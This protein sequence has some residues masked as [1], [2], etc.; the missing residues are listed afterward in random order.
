MEEELTAYNTYYPETLAYF[1]YYQTR[2][3]KNMTFGLESPDGFTYARENK[4]RISVASYKHF[5]CARRRK[6]GCTAYLHTD[7]DERRFKLYE[8]GHNCK[9]GKSDDEGLK[10]Y[11]KQWMQRKKSQFNTVT[12]VVHDLDHMLSR[13]EM[14]GR[15]R[16]NENIRRVQKMKE[17]LSD[18]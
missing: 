8:S 11:Y 7:N 18:E 6:Y 5:R 15:G 17:E 9:P 4:A 2:N 12:D 14:Q 1:T 13:P 16:A 10:Q 3:K